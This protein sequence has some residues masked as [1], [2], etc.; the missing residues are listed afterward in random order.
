MKFKLITMILLLKVLN[1]NAQCTDC[2]VKQINTDPRVSTNCEKPATANQ[3][4][5]FPNNGNNYSLLNAYYSYAGGNITGTLNNPYWAF[6]SG[7]I[8]GAL[9]GQQF[10]D[11]HPEDGWEVIKIDNGFL[12]DNTTQRNTAKSMVYMCFYNKYRGIMRFFGMLPSG[13]PWQII[14]FKITIPQYKREPVNNTYSYN[15]QKL[16]ASNTL[17]IQGNSTQPLDQETD[18]KSLEIVTQFPGG[19]PSEHFFWFEVPMAYDPCICKNDV[20][21]YLE[22]TVEQNFDL[23]IKGA[24]DGKIIQKTEVDANAQQQAYDKL[25]FNR[26][27][28]ATFATATAIATK[29]TVI[30]VSKY[31]ELL[32][33]FI[34]KPSISSTDKKKLETLQKLLKNT[35]EFV[36]DEKTQKWKN[37]FDGKEVTKDD[38]TKLFSN[39]NVYLS[40]SFDIANPSGGG[41]KT[42]TSVLGSLTATGTANTYVPQGSSI[43]WGMPGSK[44]NKNLG[45]QEIAVDDNGDQVADYIN[46]EYPIYNQILGTFAMLETPKLKIDKNPSNIGFNGF[47]ALSNNKWLTKYKITLSSDLK[48]YFNPLTNVNL[49]KTKISAAIVISNDTKHVV[50]TDDYLYSNF[51]GNYST[52]VSSTGNINPIN[53][54]RG[55]TGEEFLTQFIPI[56]KTR[57]LVGQVFVIRDNNSNFINELSEKFIYLRLL[58]EFES[59]SNGKNGKPINNTQ[60]FTF[61]VSLEEGEIPNNYPRLFSSKK[62]FD[63]DEIFSNGLDEYYSDIVSISAKLS[64]YNGVKKKIYSLVGFEL[65]PGAEISPDI[66]LIVGYPFLGTYPQPMQ[67]PEYVESFCNN[68]T[69]NLQYKANVFSQASI[70]REKEEYE[71]QARVIKEN[72]EKQKSMISFKLSPNPTKDNF[73][74]ALFNNNEQDYSIAL[75]DVTGKVLLNNLYNGKQTSQFIETNGLA[76][77]IYFVKITCGNTQ[78]TE[79]LI[80]GSNY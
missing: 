78:K 30:Q 27:I 21:I 40:G 2:E 9:A 28:G 60:I 48:Y 24:I 49:S 6:S 61:P 74:V 59:N 14:R 31:T 75:M 62:H 13:E 58:I 52:I 36:Y 17:S 5:W 72:E 25:V 64:T 69:S 55:I 54:E 43:F 51:F 29:G 65:E 26:I 77:G 56:D 47:Y 35:S 73:N 32:D 57:E 76:A 16:K 50:A 66:E 20:A 46:P 79:K 37:N 53:F 45:E 12:A 19:S 18:D 41:N 38:W 71:E 80:V 42:S 33:I 70:K 63:E 67:T 4:Y 3:F 11:F 34:Q 68:Q 22:S 10:S 1:T 23:T 44:M 39:M 15:N 8:V 7:P